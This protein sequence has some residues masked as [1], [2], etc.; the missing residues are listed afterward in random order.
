MP[1]SNLIQQS[2]ATLR[3]AAAAS[4]EV[5]LKSKTAMPLAETRG[6]RAAYVQETGERKRSL[7]TPDRAQKIVRVQQR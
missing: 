4:C 3:K 2:V 7:E 6:P 5:V 1:G